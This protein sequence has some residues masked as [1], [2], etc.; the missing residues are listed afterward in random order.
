LS[1]YAEI[2]GIVFSVRNTIRR[3]VNQAAELAQVTLAPGSVELVTRGSFESRQ[4]ALDMEQKTVC[5]PTAEK[6]D[7]LIK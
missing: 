5:K 4:Q 6:I 1:S 7:Q 2:I 3:V